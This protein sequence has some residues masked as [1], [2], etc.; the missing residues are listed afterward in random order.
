M[1]MEISEHY[2]KME[3][4]SNLIDVITESIALPCDLETMKSEI[5]PN[6]C[7]KHF[8]QNKIKEIMNL[9]LKMPKPLNQ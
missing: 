3:N 7:V 8:R 9:S 6:T 2:T 4:K 1:E 5:R